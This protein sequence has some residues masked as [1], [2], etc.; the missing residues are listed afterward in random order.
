MPRTGRRGSSTRCARRWRDWPRDSPPPLPPTTSGT[1]LRRAFDALETAVREDRRADATDADFRIHRTIVEMS[2]HRRLIADHGRLLLQVRF[3]M[4]HIGFSPRN[5]ADQVEDHR[6]LTE[7]VA[8]GDATLAERLAR[9]H[10]A[11]EVDRL[12]ARIAAAESKRED[13]G[14]EPVLTTNQQGERTDG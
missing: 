1:E 10:N 8:G 5:Y 12:Q 6:A 11:S 3:Q 9:E 2:G 4:T 13:P 14:V 7:A